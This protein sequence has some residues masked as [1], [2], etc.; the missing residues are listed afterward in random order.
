MKIPE[1]IIVVGNDS[2][3]IINLWY[4]AARRASLETGIFVEVKYEYRV[5]G[6]ISL[7][8]IIFKVMDHNFESLSA[9]QTALKNKAFL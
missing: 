6:P 1:N 9:L 7:H 5:S 3:S 8:S 4:D 2:D